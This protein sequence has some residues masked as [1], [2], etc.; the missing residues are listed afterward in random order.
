MNF[1][2]VKISKN[3]F[4]ITINYGENFTYTTTFSFDNIESSFGDNGE[5]IQNKPNIYIRY[6]DDSGM[7]CLNIFYELAHKSSDELYSFGFLPNF[8]NTVFYKINATN[9]EL[10]FQDRRNNDTMSLCFSINKNEDV[11]KVL[12]D[13]NNNILELSKTVVVM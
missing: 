12:L 6:G 9:T 2:I 8:F 3:L 1:E 7:C 11:K 4:A 5:L 13:I 10:I